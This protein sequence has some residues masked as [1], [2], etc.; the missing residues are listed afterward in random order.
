LYTYPVG[1]G[2]GAQNRIRS[3]RDVVR[4]M[5]EGYIDAVMGLKDQL[6]AEDLK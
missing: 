6:G 3:A 5:I 2:I 1:Q 4:E